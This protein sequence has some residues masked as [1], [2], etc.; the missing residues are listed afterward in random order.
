VSQSATPVRSAALVAIT[1]GLLSLASAAFAQSAE[2]GT[3]VSAAELSAKVAKTTDGTALYTVPTGPGAVV[4]AARR[5]RDGEVEVHDRLNDEFVAREGHASVRVGGRV[6]GNRQT[7][8]NEWRGGQI[9][10][11]RV[12][13][14]SP[15]DVLWIPAGMP[16]QV[17][18]PTGKSFSYLA[19]KYPKVEAAH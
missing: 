12:Y 9:T 8:P 3:Y 13:Q 16:H 2:E 18:V 11:G 5:D 4:L 19:F 14:M 15:G 7:A 10:G 1:A 17:L 6:E